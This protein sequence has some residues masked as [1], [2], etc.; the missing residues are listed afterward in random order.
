M[1]TGI[2]Y[3]S[4]VPIYHPAKIGSRPLDRPVLPLGEKK[5][6]PSD[7]RF[8]LPQQTFL[9][10]NQHRKMPYPIRTAIASLLAA[11]PLVA[12]PAVLHAQQASPGPRPTAEWIAARV[13][14]VVN[15]DVLG[16][17]M[18]S[19]SI[20]VTR[21]N[22]TL[23]ERAWGFA[24]VAASRKAEPSTV[25]EIASVSKQFT[26]A[27][28]LKLVD[29]GKLS[30]SDPIGRHVSGLQPE[31][32]AITVEQILNHTSGLKGDFRPIEH[33][34]LPT[35][36]DSL[37][38]MASR[39]TPAARP[40]TRY[41]YSNTGYMLAGVIIEK[42]YGK[43]YADVLRDEIAR[44]LG[45][46]SLRLC[47]TDK[48]GG[49]RSYARSAQAKP[50]PV[51]SNHPSQMLGNG[52]I[53]TTASDLAKW[54]RALHGGRVLSP[55]SYAAMT[56]PRGAVAASKNSGL[57]IFV[58]PAPWGSM[59]MVH[60]GTTVGY[61][62]ANAWY[63]ADSISVVVLYNGVPRLPVDVD[64]IIGGIAHGRTPAPKPQAVPQAAQAEPPVTLADT[65]QAA[66]P[67]DAARYVGDYEVRPGMVF[68]VTLENGILFIQQPT[69]VGGDKHPLL[70]KSG[71]TFA[72]GNTEGTVTM[73]F[74]SDS[75][76]Q[77]V[78]MIMRQSG[79]ERKLKKVR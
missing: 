46:S 44:P 67:A 78:E 13:D 21:G 37:L 64:G 69:L 17:G 1:A 24:D 22:E 57:G 9:S 72:P 52:G 40:G 31:F 12:M 58:R 39:D 47:T 29:R 32:N 10:P 51:T 70:L 45:L 18:P 25:Y 26:A 56:T 71:T 79:N 65:P 14:S 11:L 38:A 23:V 20:V 42:L 50:E 7:L 59:A 19:V 75:S 6:V 5:L 15:T 66:A 60:E 16:Q 55:T 49:A 61:A 48:T 63:P 8:T 35:T 4:A 30:L 33:M 34:T 3:H 36:K 74:V 77:V 68:V 73:T 2:T 28:I 53:C 62:S 41:A 43:P 27:L 54:N 76:G